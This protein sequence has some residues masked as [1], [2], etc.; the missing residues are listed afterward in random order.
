MWNVVHLEPNMSG[1]TNQCRHCSEE[2][3]PPF[4]ALM[5]LDDL[6][7]VV[8]EFERQYRNAMGEPPRL[9][10]WCDKGEPT[11]H[12][13]F[14]RMV[15][16][17]RSFPPASGPWTT[18]GTN[19]YGLARTDDWKSV[20]RSLISM[21]IR[22]LG[23]AVHGPE[24]EHD[25]FA[26]RRG[27]YRDIVVAARRGLESDMEVLFEIHLNKRNLSMF[28]AI[29]DALEELG[30]GRAKISSGIDAYFMNER[31][32]TLEPLRLTKPERDEI[33]ELLPRAPDR[34]SDTEA[35]L[36][37]SLAERGREAV[38]RETYEPAGKG[39]EGRGLGLFLVSPTFDVTERFHS[40]PSL[41][42]GNLKRDGI[43]KVWR[44]V[45]DAVLPPMSEPDEIASSY[46][47]FDS[48]ALHP[49]VDSVYM[50]LCDEYWHAHEKR[51]VT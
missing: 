18:L 40:R 43:E 23:F 38:L 30:D 25:W 34:G 45:L 32:R 15:E 21:G 33:A 6:K 20:F 14:L 37:G 1:C 4:G 2:G 3:S 5:S 48:E 12:P 22:G 19:G 46:G 17:V 44:S 10:L 39:P 42:H 24:E 16:Y 47:H 51:W 36:T 29:L 35:N 7:W 13:D 11:A 27:A 8:G 26:R 41:Y 50:K 9:R 49:G 31:L 28:P